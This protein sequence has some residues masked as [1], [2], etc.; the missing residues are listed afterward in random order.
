M[1]QDYKIRFVKDVQEDLSYSVSSEQ[2]DLIMNSIIKNLNDYDIIARCTDL[3][4]YESSNDRILN[5]YCACLN[6]DGK[7][8]KTIYQY[9]RAV[10]RL[11]DFLEKQFTDMGIYD[12]RYYLACE[13][14][15]GISSRTLENTRANLSA[16]FQW[17]TDDEVIPKN[18]LS[19]LKPIKYTDEIRKPFS[20]IEIDT[21]RYSCKN[22]RERAIIELLLSSGIRVSE[23]CAMEISDIDFSN[24]SVHV[25]HGKGGKQRTTYITPI[26]AN[27]IQE[28][29]NSR[30]ETGT[31]LFYNSLHKQIEPGGG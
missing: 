4:P 14:D 2:L 25:R 10:Q 28:Y 19:S 29:L 31:H 13:K 9:R 1:D 6:V 11:S 21:M 30:K 17:M 15:R 22:K 16:F 26:A 7:S 12:I 27:H 8:E 5:R 20:E 18:P 23:L 24:L 3:V